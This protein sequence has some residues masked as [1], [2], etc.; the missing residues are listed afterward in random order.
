MPVA[1]GREREVEWMGA[2]GWR[3][4]N[5]PCKFSSPDSKAGGRGGSPSQEKRGRPEERRRWHFPAAGT[6]E[7]AGRRGATSPVA[8][9]AGHNSQMPPGLDAPWSGSPPPPARLPLPPPLHQSGGSLEL[10]PTHCSPLAT[11][12]IGNLSVNCGGTARRQASMDSERREAEGEKQRKS[13]RFASLCRSWIPFGHGAPPANKK[14][15]R[16]VAYLA[17]G[18]ERQLQCPKRVSDPDARF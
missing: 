1:A 14:K 8:V 10:H 13:F 4:R 16:R 5:F 7:D 9:S 2:A 11:P 12:R 3:R 17:A 6:A 18:E 15:Q